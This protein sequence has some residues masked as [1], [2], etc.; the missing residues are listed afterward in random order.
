M[1]ANHSQDTAK[2]NNAK[3]RSSN[4]LTWLLL[5]LMIPLAVWAWTMYQ[6]TQAV[7]EIDVLTRDGVITE[8]QE[9]SRLQTVGYSVDTI[10]TTQK[11]GNWYALWQDEQKGLFVAH[12]RVLAGVDLQKITP[13]DIR[14]S[15]K[16][17]VAVDDTGEPQV[18]S[19]SDLDITINLPPAEI[20]EVF[21]EDIEV[22]DMRRGLFN[23]MQPDSDMFKQAQALGKSEVLAKACEGE[24]LNLAAENAKRQVQ[25][26]F[27]MTGASVTINYR[28]SSYY[29]DTVEL[30]LLDTW[31]C[32]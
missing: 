14:V 10:I 31:N 11:Q 29:Q 27:A 24:V 21:L 2:A 8:I 28:D 23:L 1:T 12:G 25:S 16:P 32:V 6:Q 18:T 3:K 7:P 9:M 4:W 26:L 19:D 5:L 22:Y 15:P 20:F 13:D 17:N 30:G